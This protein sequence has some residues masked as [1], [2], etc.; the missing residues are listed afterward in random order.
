MVSATFHLALHTKGVLEAEG[1]KTFLSEKALPQNPLSTAEV[2]KNGQTW[3]SN[4]HFLAALP[5]ALLLARHVPLG[6]TA[7]QAVRSG[8]D[9]ARDHAQI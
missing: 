3:S 7:G 2:F 6:L 8:G 4:R 9:S 5:Q 1:L